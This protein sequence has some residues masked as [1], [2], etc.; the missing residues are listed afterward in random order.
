MIDQATSRPIVV[1]FGPCNDG[2]RNFMM[3]WRTPAPDKWTE[4]GGV[5]ETYPEL[6]DVSIFIHR[7]T[8]L[9]EQ[10]IDTVGCTRDQATAIIE[11]QPGLD[12]F[13]LE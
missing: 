3:I 6:W 9:F 10:I 11:D 1:Q 2:F 12:N 13:E 4:Q 8:G 5:V 7:G